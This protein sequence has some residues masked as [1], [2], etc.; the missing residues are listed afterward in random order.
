MEQLLKGC[1]NALPTDQALYSEEDSPNPEDSPDF[2]T[3]YGR[4]IMESKLGNICPK[5]LFLMTPP[6]DNWFAGLVCKIS[7]NM[8]FFVNRKTQFNFA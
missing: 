5:S 3:N 1:K 4:C 7:S 6:P 2:E 8:K